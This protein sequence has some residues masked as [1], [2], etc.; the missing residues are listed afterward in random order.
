MSALPAVAEAGPEP[1][2]WSVLRRVAREARA[3]RRQIVTALAEALNVDERHALM[4]LAATLGWPV[5]DTP[6]M[7]VLAA[8]W[9]LVP[10]AE[11]MRRGAVLLR[12]Q[13]AAHDCPIAVVGDPLDAD[14]Q[15]WLRTRAG[16]DVV[17]QLA[18]PSDLQAFLGKQ[19]EAVRTVE[20]LLDREVEAGRRGVG[21]ETLSFANISAEAHPV[22][23]LVSSTIYDALKAG[24]SDIH[25][26]STA[27]GLQLKYRLD[28][29]LD[30]AGSVTGVDTAEQVISR[31][32]V[33]AELDIAERRIPQDGSFRVHTEDRDIDLRLSI[34]PSV[35]GEDAVVRILDKRGMLLPNGSL[36]LDALGLD[37]DARASLRRLTRQAYGMVLVTGPT[38]SGKTTTLYGAL[39]E[40]HTGRDKIITIEDPV[41]YQLAGVLQIPVHE[42]K[43]LTFAKGLRSILRHDPDI[44]MV[45]EIRDRETAEIAVQSALTGHLVFSTVHANGVFDVFSRF[46]H[47]GID[48]YAFSSALNG[49]WAQRLMRINCTRCSRPMELSAEQR[50]RLGLPDDATL[51]TGVG[52]GDCRGTGYRGRRAIAEVLVLDD[53]LRELI[54]RKA[55]VRELKGLAR[56]KG[57]TR[58]RDAALKL[59]AAGETTVAEVERVTLDA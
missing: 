6:R 55:P 52:C 41:E 18:L 14:L 47:M 16:G 56:T 43:G 1:I 51:K 45:G 40:R 27:T 13:G 20:S 54:V 29:V 42:K 3:A 21:A 8:D 23:R 50:V 53:E 9:A 24:A 30:A 22:V 19:E 57:A 17:W 49:V 4:R 44:I 46:A 48:P 58:L 35:Y 39:A 28:G 2:E 31:L 26:E 10:L 25:F 7:L 15:T 34:M 38:G 32:K 37:A 59:L 5:L 11:A 12:D 36:T 33:L